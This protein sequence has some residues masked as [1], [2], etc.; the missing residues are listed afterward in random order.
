[1]EFES[2]LAWSQADPIL[3][4]LSPVHTLTPCLFIIHLIL[5][6]A[7]TPWSPNL[8]FPY[9]FLTKILYYAFFISLIRR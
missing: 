7:S 2:S 6:L 3:S 9:I 1:M 8:S 5:S 4:Q